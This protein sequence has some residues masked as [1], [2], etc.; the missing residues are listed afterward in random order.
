[1]K[2]VPVSPSNGK[3]R[4]GARLRAAR[5]RQGLTIDQ[6]A[7]SAEVT[8]GFISR[9]ERDETS[10]SVATLVTL[11][12]VLSLPIGTLFESP[13]TAVVRKADAPHIQLAGAGAEERLL[14]P[15]GQARLQLVRS[16][17]EPG[18]TGGAELY[19]LNCEVEVLHVLKGTI[20]VVFSSS[21]ERLNAGDTMTFSGREPHSW[22]NPDPSRGAE[23]L[24]VI[25][26]APWDMSA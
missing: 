18:G 25:S 20:E 16:V 4:I 21:T 14:T 17:I 24:W 10:P 19:T 1:M 3:L 11:C 12:E 15:R 26:P 22:I 2:P 7:A 8:K 6:V 5:Q 13:E 9:I 23:V